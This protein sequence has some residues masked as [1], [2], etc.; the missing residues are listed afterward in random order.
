MKKTF[1]AAGVLAWV[2]LGIIPLTTYAVG[3]FVTG[4]DPDFH[5]FASDSDMTGARH[6]IQRAVAYVTFDKL[7]P[8]LLLVTDLRDP[9]A[10]Y[11]DPRLGMTAAGFTYDV[12]DY[13]SGTPGV[14]DLNTVDFNNY[15]AI[16]VASDYGGWL[17][18]DELDILNARSAELTDYVN[19]GNR[20]IVAFSESGG[21]DLTTHNRYGFLPFLV[22]EVTFHQ[23]EEGFTVTAAGVA[24]GL[25]DADVNGNF[26]HSSFVETGGMDVIDI[27]AA[28]RFISLAT[29][30]TIS[31]G[32]VE[33]CDNGID[34]DGDGLIDC[35]DP[36]CANHPSCAIPCD[37]NGDGKVNMADWKL[38]QGAKGKCPGQP[39]YIPQADCDH[40]GGCIDKY[41]WYCFYYC[42]KHNWTY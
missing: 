14:L 20:G 12:A 5:A 29:R 8:M 2:L 11:I 7:N 18:Q 4:H 37:L 35:A 32:G 40:S 19:T 28:G 6:I 42:A 10:G 33:V 26:S 30:K 15:D 34:D 22:S 13:G 27:D 38:M 25:T 41:D 24:M 36:D 23:T 39:G 3:V 17:R 16:V 9:G 31:T 1:M 21:G